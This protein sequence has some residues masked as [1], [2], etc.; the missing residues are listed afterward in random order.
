M[1]G[2]KNPTAKTE[3]KEWKK[4][5]S[6]KKQPSAY[7]EAD[8]SMHL[9]SGHSEFASDGMND[10]GSPDE[11]ILTEKSNSEMVEEN[12]DVDFDGTKHNRQV[13]ILIFLVIFIQVTSTKWYKTSEEY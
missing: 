2:N 3:G 12:L 10:T 1:A 4:F 9:K 5:N 11:V 6:K 8:F 13:K 7:T